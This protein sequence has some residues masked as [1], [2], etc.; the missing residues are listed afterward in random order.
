MIGKF[1]HIINSG[2]PVLVD[3][4][5]E[6]CQPCKQ[7]PMVLKKVKE[8][9]RD[10]VRIIK[11]DVDKNPHIATQYQ[12][13]SIPT[14]ILFKNGEAKWTAMGVRTAAEIKMKVQQQIDI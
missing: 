8:E 3:F 4:Y 1:K 6:W 14:V 5:A 13:R 11:V 12:I 10:Q 7:M 2:R 9:L